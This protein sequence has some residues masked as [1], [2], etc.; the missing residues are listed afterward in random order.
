MEK[1]AGDAHRETSDVNIRAILGFGAALVIAAVIIH[2]LIWLLF[3]FFQRQENQAATRLFP[4]AA[5]QQNRLPPEPRLQTDPQGDLRDLRQREDAILRS[6]GWI[7]KDAG[8]VR[9]PIEDAIRLTIE[10]GLPARP[11]NG[12]GQ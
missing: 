4:L 2:A 10:R 9:L 7:S 5:E 11:A 1:M 8:A 3:T 6:Y 12:T